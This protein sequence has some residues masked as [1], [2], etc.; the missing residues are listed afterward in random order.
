MK[1]PHRCTFLKNMAFFAALLGLSPATRA[2]ADEPPPQI[3][4]PEYYE[5]SIRDQIELTVYG[6]PDLSVAQRIDSRGQVRVPLLGTLKIAGMTVRQAEQFIQRTYVEKRILRDPMVTIRVAEYAPKEVAV[7][8]AVV[9]PGKLVFPIEANSLDIVD[10]IS[11]MGGF[12]GIAKSDHVRVTRTGTNGEKQE[13]TVNVERMITGRGGDEE[14]KVEIL[15][16][17]II[18]VPERIF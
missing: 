5:L 1:T 3:T 17:D 11:Q 14:K 9:S 6:E 4:M 18:W 15:P 8:G 7:L 13:F 16:G 2:P 10:V 12:Q